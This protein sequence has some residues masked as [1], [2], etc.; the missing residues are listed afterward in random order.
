M[1]I[2]E[3]IQSS[4]AQAEKLRSEATQN[5]KDLIEK[6]RMLTTNMVNEMMEEL[7]L[8]EKS[9]LENAQ[10]R[11]LLKQDEL[12]SKYRKLDVSNTFSAA[13]KANEV[14]NFIVEKVIST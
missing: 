12:D 10:K 13:Q 7:K 11:V 4:E 5:A 8:K 3:S 9:I 14:A 6:T 2:L 1:S